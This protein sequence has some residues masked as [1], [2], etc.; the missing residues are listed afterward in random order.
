M[1]LLKDRGYTPN[2]VQSRYTSPDYARGVPGVLR[3]TQKPDKPRPDFPLFPHDR[4]KWAKKIKGKLVYFGRWEDPEHALSEYEKYIAGDSGPGIAVEE[5]GLTVRDACNAFFAAKKEMVSQGTMSQRTLTDYKRSVLSF[6]TFVGIDRLVESL[7]PE[8]FT[9]YKNHF[10]KSNNLVTTGN[11]ITRIKSAFKWL[12]ASKKIA[13]P[14]FG[15]DFRKPPAKAVR[16]Y[17]REK[18]LKLFTAEDIQA[19]LDESGYRMKAMIFLGINCGYHNADIETL[20][21]STILS[22]VKTGTIEHAR[23]KTEVDRA[24]P[25]WPETQNALNDW[26]QKRPDCKSDLAFVLRDGAP[27]SSVN[28]DVAKRFRSVRDAAGV[29][30]GGFSWLRKTFATY[31]SESNDQ[32]AVDF[33]MGHVDDS[34]PGIYRQLVR[35]KRLEKVVQVVRE[36]FL[37]PSS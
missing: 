26:I 19:I 7:T 20:K 2:A 28:T 36:W 29:R 6:G 33:I 32:V 25:L 21:L 35:G 23:T 22:A 16:K 9:K 3:M 12:V 10:A 5:F 13:Q 30:L 24:C 27:L 31:A 18:G 4:G 8:D 11:E 17:R 1:Y 15:P 37:S 14:E 34:I